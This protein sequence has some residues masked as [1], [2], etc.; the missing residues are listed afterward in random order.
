MFSSCSHHLT[1]DDMINCANDG[2]R[3]AGRKAKLFRVFGADFDHPTLP[4]LREG[5]YLKSL[6]FNVE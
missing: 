2:F 6:C 5:E 1:V 4:S 3:K